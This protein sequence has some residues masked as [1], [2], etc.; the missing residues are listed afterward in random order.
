[1]NKRKILGIVFALIALVYSVIFT[2]HTELQFSIRLESW[3]T[4]SYLSLLT[5]FIICA[6]LLFSGGYLFTKQT[7]S[8]FALA[9]FGHTASEEVVFNWIGITT[10]NLT[11]NSIVVL[12]ICSVVAL[13]IAYSNTFNFRP[14]SLKEV[15][16]SVII[17]TMISLFQ[18]AVL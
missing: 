16:Y 7:K 17:G 13:W 8:N 3:L 1:M 6:M 5:P 9:L 2:I 4:L 14:I 18:L 15:I 11:P 10:T 12:F